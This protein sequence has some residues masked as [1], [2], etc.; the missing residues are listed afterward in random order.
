MPKPPEWMD[1]RRVTCKG[2]K[3]IEMP[4]ILSSFRDKLLEDIDNGLDFSEEE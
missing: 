2:G 3:R 1:K 4:M